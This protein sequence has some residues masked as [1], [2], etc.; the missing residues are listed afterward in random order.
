M[1]PTWKPGERVQSCHLGNG[2]ACELACMQAC[3]H[4]CVRRVDAPHK[5]HKIG[6]IPLLQQGIHV[7][8]EA[9]HII[10]CQKSFSLIKC[11]QQLHLIRHVFESIHQHYTL[12]SVSSQELHLCKRE[13]VGYVLTDVLKH[14][15]NRAMAPDASSTTI[16][17]GTNPN[18]KIQNTLLP[19]STG[20]H[21]VD[22][23]SD[24]Y[25]ETYVLPQDEP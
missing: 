22:D 21:R 8:D 16:T 13:Y 11:K 19:H 25:F 2:C 3:E 24:I 10:S 23:G 14:G 5:H 9:L 12:F 4:A 1:A 15:R 7:G 18:T 6:A 20:V 17:N